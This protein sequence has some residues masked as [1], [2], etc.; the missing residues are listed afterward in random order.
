MTTT[1]ALP[2]SPAEPEGPDERPGPDVPD[3]FTQG[4]LRVVA[5]ID[6]L[7]DDRGFDTQSAYVETFW[8][9]VLG[10]SATWILRHLAQ[11][12]E[13]SPEGFSVDLDELAG[14]LGLG[15]SQR[16]NAPFR[17]ALGRL[18]RFGMARWSGPDLAVRLRVSAVPSRHLGRLPRSVQAEHERR[19][20][21]GAA[22]EA[23]A[24]KPEPASPDPG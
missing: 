19:L 24:T 6:P 17:R 23:R 18:V 5:W 4:R 15:T 7:V 3:V 14:Q 9:G 13:Q 20:G 8:L 16:R 11:R 22:G 10:P 12:L 21:S 1:P 2:R